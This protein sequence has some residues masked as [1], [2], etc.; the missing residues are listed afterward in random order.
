MTPQDKALRKGLIRLANQKPEFRKDLLPLLKTASPVDEGAKKALAALA[1]AAKLPV[2]FTGQ[3]DEKI[4]VKV[5]A[6]FETLFANLWI[7]V[8]WSSKGTGTVSWT[9]EHP[10]GSNG[11]TIGRVGFDPKKGQWLWRLDTGGGGYVDTAAP[12]PT[13]E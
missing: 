12:A 3:G 6:G 2:S 8:Q 4:A 9:Y 13:E 11:Y 5:P 1:K 10:S 7:T